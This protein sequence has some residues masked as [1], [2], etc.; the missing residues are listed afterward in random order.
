M[1]KITAIVLARMNCNRCPGK[2]MSK[3]CGIPVIEIVLRRLSQATKIS[4]IVLATSLSED[5]DILEQYVKKIGF[6][7]FRGSEHD[8]IERLLECCDIYSND[9]YF[10]RCCADN[11]FI[12]KDEIDK[13]VSVG[14]E[15]NWDYVGFK[16]DV[17]P[18]RISDFAG[19]F[20]KI[21]ALKKV[22]KMT[23]DKSDREHV[24][25]FFE[26]H[27][28]IFK[29]TRILTSKE[30]HT[31]VKLDLDYPEDLN[32]LQNIAIQVPNIIQAQSSELVKIANT[33]QII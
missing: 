23:N 31:P 6:D 16:N 7:V 10:L 18:D 26:K 1:N 12:D 33:L 13:V 29:T 4:N 30:L 28:E 20:Y 17:Y 22:S 3:V 14:I 9:H 24:F 32:R 21:G 25:P 27:P 8:V 15:G 5:D 19:E 2:N 11:V